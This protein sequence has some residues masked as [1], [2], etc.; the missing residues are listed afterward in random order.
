MS[1]RFEIVRTDGGQPWHARY[2]ASN[3]RIVWSTE[4]YVEKR[5]A[6]NAIA[7]VAQAFSLTRVHFTYR[8]DVPHIQAQGVS[9]EVREVDER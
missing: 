9:A 7:V 1:A 4:Q 8:R 2:I 6:K 5:H 3:G